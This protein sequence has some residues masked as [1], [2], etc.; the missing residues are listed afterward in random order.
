LYLTATPRIG[1][2]ITRGRELVVVSMDDEAVFGPVLY[3]YPFGR[4]S[5]R[6]G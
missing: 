4:G 1:T 5:P 2:G 6:G 3:A